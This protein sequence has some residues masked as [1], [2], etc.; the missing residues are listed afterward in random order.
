MNALARDLRVAVRLLIKERRFSIAAIA[1]LVVGITAT[2]TVFTIVY[3]VVARPL[4]FVDAERVVAIVTRNIGNNAT[5]QTRLSLPDLD[6]LRQASRTLER[7]GGAFESEVT[8]GDEQGA[9]L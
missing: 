8:L 1:T 9:D 6:D 3:P 4:P 7:I 2:T 5:A